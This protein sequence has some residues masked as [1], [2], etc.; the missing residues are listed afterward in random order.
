[1][2]FKEALNAMNN[3]QAVRRINDWPKNYIVFTQIP[4]TISEEIIP[5]MTSV[6]NEVKNIILNN[7][8]CISYHDQCIMLNVETGS[9]EYFVPTIKNCNAEDWEIVTINNY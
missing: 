9:A 2:N 4:Q 3:G 5:K 6:P 7:S 8:K 1:M